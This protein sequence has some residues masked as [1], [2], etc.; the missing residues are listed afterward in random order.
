MAWI[1]T[2]RSLDHFAELYHQIGGM[3][4]SG[5]TLVQAIELVRAAP[6]A[7]AFRGRLDGIL[8]E[9]KQGSTFSEALDNQ[10]GWL[11]EFDVALIAAGEKSGRLDVSCHRLSD[12]YRERAKL[13]RG[14]IADLAYP[15][16]VVLLL[17]LVFPPGA[18]AGLVWQGDVAGFLVPKLKLLG[19][20]AL[21]QVL[22]LIL[23]RSNRGGWWRAA[24]EGLLH[25]VPILGQA[26]RSMALG[27]MAMALE[28]LL[29]AGVNVLE[30]WE[31]AAKASGSPA[32]ARAI[33][34]AMPR[35]AA[36]ETPGEAI[37]PTGV[38]P[39][40]FVSLYRS[41]EV[42]GR[43]DQSL[44]YLSQDY[45]DEGSRLFKRLAEW[46]PRLVFILVAMMIGYFVV[47]FYIGYFDN[48][49]ESIDRATQGL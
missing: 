26:R 41:G 37:G 23:S 49:L 15:V 10:R 13:L 25:R 17:I 48:M 30:S 31:L 1:T 21:A 11:P 29:N 5:V 33:G 39:A 19:L 44:K 18:L 2:P 20:L 40:K 47:T 32:L 9:L 46:M 45:T 14:A 42:S 35:M 27:R 7:G 22:F 3:L 36:G 34:R 6:P 16:F 4:T 12:Y 8:G 43:V 38:F 24:W 28:A